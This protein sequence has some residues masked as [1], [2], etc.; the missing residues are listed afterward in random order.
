MRALRLQY[1][2]DDSASWLVR[3]TVYDENAQVVEVNT[4]DTPDEVPPE[5]GIFDWA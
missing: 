1:D 5:Y 4:Y 3:A 2:G